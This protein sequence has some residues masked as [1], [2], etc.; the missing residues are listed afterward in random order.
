MSDSPLPCRD[1][2][3]G[4]SGRPSAQGDKSY[5]NRLPIANSDD[6]PQSPWFK[7]LVL[8]LG[9][10]ALR[11]NDLRFLGLQRFLSN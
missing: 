2:P 1:G 10:V 11:F 4:D 6:A 8:S 3:H 7:K 5:P 9:I